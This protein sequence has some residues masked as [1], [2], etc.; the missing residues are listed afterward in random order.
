MHI[1]FWVFWNFWELQFVLNILDFTKFH[2]RWYARFQL[3]QIQVKRLFPALRTLCISHLQCLETFLN[4]SVLSTF[5]L[6]RSFYSVYPHHANHSKHSLNHRFR[7]CAN[8]V[9]HIYSVLKRFGIFH[10]LHIVA[11]AKL[12]LR[13]CASCKLWLTQF[14]PWLPALRTLCISDLQCFETFRIPVCFSHFS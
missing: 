4:C 3:S 1:T 13:W 2:L 14:K 11:S 9:Y 7:H 8:C 5:L 12:L 10:F 6:F